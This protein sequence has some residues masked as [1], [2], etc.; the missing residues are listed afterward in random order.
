MIRTCIYLA[1]MLFAGTLAA[2]GLEVIPLKYQSAEEVIPIIRPILGNDGVVTGTGYKLIVRAPAHRVEEIRNLLAEIDRPLQQLIISV[3]QGQE[4]AIQSQRSNVAG[5]V[6]GDNGRIVFGRPD[7]A[8]GGLSVNAYN[9]D[10]FVQGQLS[11]RD[12]SY[13]DN[14]S[15]Q[16]RT[17]SG[18]PAFIS[19]GRSLPVPEQQVIIQGNRVIT[20]GTTGYYDT[21]TGFYVTPRLNGDRVTLEIYTQRDTPRR[22]DI[23]T[24][25]ISTVVSGRLGDWIPLGGTSE[26]SNHSGSR[27][28]SKGNRQMSDL[29]D[30]SVKVTLAPN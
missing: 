15:Q 3:R 18:Q 26:T 25:A 28:Y 2:A 21:R 30:I 24:S 16:V 17:I 12:D 10:D 6:G 8:P 4:A 13:Q 5:S 1:L 14:I 11:G 29:R 9:S 7:R 19:V 27:M 20:T 23:D 22:Y